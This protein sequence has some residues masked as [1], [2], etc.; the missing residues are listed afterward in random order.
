MTGVSKYDVA[1]Q[2]SLAG[3][4]DPIHIGD[5]VSAPDDPGIFVLPATDASKNYRVERNN[6]RSDG[7]DFLSMRSDDVTKPGRTADNDFGHDDFRHDVVSDEAIALPRDA[8]VR[9]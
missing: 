7:E 2:I 8:T 3:I 6:G 5:Y 9:W 4:P 1:D